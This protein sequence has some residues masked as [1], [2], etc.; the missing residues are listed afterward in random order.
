MSSIQ[1]GQKLVNFQRSTP[2]C[3][4]CQF[5]KRERDEVQNRTERTCRKHMWIVIMS[6]TC[7]DHQYRNNRN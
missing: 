2:I 1:N 3:G 7:S 4:N 6:G 5:E